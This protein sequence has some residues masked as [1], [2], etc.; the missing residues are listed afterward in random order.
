MQLGN[1]VSLSVTSADMVADFGPVHRSVSLVLPAETL[2]SAWIT[3][4]AR[5]VPW[6][7]GGSVAGLR[8]FSY[9][10]L[11]DYLKTTE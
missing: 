11:K 2:S 8:D 7:E 9:A 10:A 5:V 3:L 1:R 4:P 6:G